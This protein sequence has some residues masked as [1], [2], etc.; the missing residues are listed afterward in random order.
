[1]AGRIQQNSCW[2][3]A[4]LYRYLWRSLFILY[5]SVI[6]EKQF[7]T[8]FCR[9]LFY[10]CWKQMMRWMIRRWTVEVFKVE[11]ALCSEKSAVAVVVVVVVVLLLRSIFRFR[12]LQLLLMD[13]LCAFLILAKPNIWFFSDATNQD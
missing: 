9:F 5:S 4:S 3:A 10:I 12:T 2:L 8:H 13:S 7:K 11:L 1:M 6:A